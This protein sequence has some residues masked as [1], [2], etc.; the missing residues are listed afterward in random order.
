MVAGEAD[1][2]GPAVS[3]AAAHI[4]PTIAEEA[5][6]MDEPKLCWSPGT[7]ASRIR[8][9]GSDRLSLSNAATARGKLAEAREPDRHVREGA[10][11]FA[12]HV[13]EQPCGRG[14]E[15]EED[16]LQAMPGADALQMSKDGGH[17]SFEHD[18]RELPNLEIVSLGPS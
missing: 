15:V 6:R 16:V 4:P 17:V 1:E 12:P 10:Q 11:V 13:A 3:G 7:G 18:P 14:E 5:S 2:L 9:R 8:P